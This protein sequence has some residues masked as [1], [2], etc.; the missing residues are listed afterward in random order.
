M[1]KCLVTGAAGF[2]GFHLCLKLINEGYNVVGIDNMNNYYDVNLKKD[3]VKYLEKFQASSSGTKFNFEIIDL[4]DSD[5]IRRLIKEFEPQTVCHLAAQAGVRYSIENPY[6][7]IDNNI[8]G[9]VNLLEA[10]KDYGVTDIV[11]AST[12]SVYGLN[13]NM[14]FVEESSTDTPISTYA[15]TKKSCELLLHTYNNLYKIR[16]RILRFFLQYMD[17]GAGQ[18]WRFSCLQKQ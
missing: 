12:S 6:T 3:R 4:K 8:T 9:T 7:Y 14:P 13:E 5:K 11:F 2:I 16:V 18:I 17:L 15:S 10:S 1:K